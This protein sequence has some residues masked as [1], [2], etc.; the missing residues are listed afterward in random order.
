MNIELKEEVSFEL[1]LREAEEMDKQELFKPDVVESILDAIKARV[2]EFKPDLTT[3]KGR[4]EIASV[5]SK[6]AKSKTFLD[7][8]GKDVVADWKAKAKVI[9]GQRKIIR[10]TL[11]AMKEEVRKPLTEWEEAEEKRQEKINKRI[12]GIKA[13]ADLTSYGSVTSDIIKQNL[14][15]VKSIEIDDSF[16]EYKDLAENE[17]DNAINI[18]Q[19]RLDRQ[20]EHEEEQAELAELR[21]EKE[22]REKKEAAEKAEAERK[23]QEEKIRKEAEEK[24]KLEEEKKSK[25]AIA[26]IEAEKQELIRKQ[27][28][29][30]AKA[31]AEQK[32][33]EEEERKRIADEN[34][35]KAIED[36]A[37][38]CIAKIPDIS[39]LKIAKVIIKAIS[40]N[41]IK[42]VSI[43][44]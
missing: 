10:D 5:A 20:L 3:A 26:K 4:K 28:E 7:G 23:A 36:E 34:H 1:V 42:N 9:D 31:E 2:K 6:V 8:I 32:W 35:R 30:K 43:N 15:E 12:L 25:E 22:E 18:L 13:A 38:A 29:E 24:A 19:A 39:N 17:K 44:Y 21:K 27:E 37:I 16:A 40:E 33:K 14:D 41:K 11:D